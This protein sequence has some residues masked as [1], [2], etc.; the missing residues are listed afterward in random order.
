MKSGDQV[1]VASNNNLSPGKIVRFY[2]NHGTV[3]VQMTNGK[4]V[5]LSY[6]DLEKQF[7]L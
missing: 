4:L 7:V 1:K 6:E 2:A 3:L 5:Y